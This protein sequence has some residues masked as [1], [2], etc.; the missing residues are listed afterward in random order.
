MQILLRGR[1]YPSLP[2]FPLALQPEDDLALQQQQQ[3]PHPVLQL[4]FRYYITRQIIPAMDRLFSLLPPPASADLLQWFRDMP[5]P[6]QR[7][8]APALSSGLVQQQQLLPQQLQQRQQPSLLQQLG[9]RSLTAGPTARERLVLQKFFATASCLFCGIKCRELG[10]TPLGSCKVNSGQFPIPKKRKTTVSTKPEDNQ[11]MAIRRNLLNQLL[12]A[13]FSS[14]SS[15]SSEER[16]VGDFHEIPKKTKRK[17]NAIDFKR[18]KVVVPPP[19]CREC[20]SNPAFVCV[21]MY[22]RLKKVERRIAAGRSFCTHCAGESYNTCDPRGAHT[23]SYV[24][25]SF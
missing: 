11:E 15:S 20:S 7:M 25:R 19:I 2:P 16:E 21:R 9:I 6:A 4:H 23:C 5:K 1:V 10:P 13:A 22:E 18:E 8:Y 14:S 24:R 17:G 12:Q 3:Q